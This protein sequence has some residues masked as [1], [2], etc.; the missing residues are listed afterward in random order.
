MKITTCFTSL[1]QAFTIHSFHS[2]PCGP[3][4]LSSMS[5]L[6]SIDYFRM[7]GAYLPLAIAA[8]NWTYKY[9]CMYVEQVDTAD[10]QR[11]MCGEKV[12]YVRPRLSSY[13]WFSNCLKWMWT[14][15][16]Y[17]R[18]FTYRMCAAAAA[19]CE[20]EWQYKT[21][22]W[23]RDESIRFVLLCTRTKQNIYAFGE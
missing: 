22:A 10:V 23:R 11:Y 12:Y 16:K 4:P 13:R 21:H 5:D 9:I 2:F 8:F 15:N 14:I 3:L 20:Y 19:V 1:R 6:F 18:T 7:L 17:P